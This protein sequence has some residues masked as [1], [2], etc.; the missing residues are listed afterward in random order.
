V[1][2]PADAHVVDATNKYVTPGFIDVNVHVTGR[3]S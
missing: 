3:A 2:V 1:K